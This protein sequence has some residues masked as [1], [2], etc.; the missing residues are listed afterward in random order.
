M[1][2][3]SPDAD[4]DPV[5]ACVRAMRRHAGSS[6][7]QLIVFGSRATDT[8]SPGSDVDLLVVIEPPAKTWRASN[9]VAERR[10]LQLV[11][12]PYCP[13]PLDLWVR[14]IDQFDEAREVIGGVEYLAATRGVI[15][16]SAPHEREPVKQRTREEIRYQNVRDLVDDSLRVLGEAVRSELP[17]TVDRRQP[18]R[19]AEHLAWRAIQH[20]LCAVFAWHQVETP[21][22]ADELPSILAKL[23]HADPAGL[24]RLRS[25]RES[26]R[27]TT[28]VARDVARE[29]VTVLAR[30]PVLAPAFVSVRARLAMPLYRFADLRPLK[31]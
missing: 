20:A 5:A 18:P 23:S 22:K 30:D 26:D 1:R 4:V 2:G 6:L 7:R 12:Q 16:Y 8:F 14:T 3:A 11:V 10:R 13:L 27:P 15:M 17:N 31:D 28:N 19:R 21:E 29:V 9:N 24:L 25:L